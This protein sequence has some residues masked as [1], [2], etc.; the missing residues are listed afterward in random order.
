[1]PREGKQNRSGKAA[2]LEL[3]EL[4]NLFSELDDPY[5]A[6]AQLC[7]L[8]AGRIGEVLF[9]RGDRRFRIT[10]SGEAYPLNQGPFCL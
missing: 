4:Q 6:I 2:I 8:T 1:M 10:V 3:E 5:R 7:Y 9:S